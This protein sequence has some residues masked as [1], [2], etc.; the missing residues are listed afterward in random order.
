[1]VFENQYFKDLDYT[2]SLDIKHTIN[3]KLNIFKSPFHPTLPFLE[4]VMTKN[5][6]IVEEKIF[7]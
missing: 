7:H 5:Q 4:E 6:F 1:M 3:L 2:S